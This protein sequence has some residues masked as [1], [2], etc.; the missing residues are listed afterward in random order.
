MKHA[1]AVLGLALLPLASPA[2]VQVQ[3]MFHGV[4][5]QLVDLDP[6]DGIAPAF[7]PGRASVGASLIALQP[8]G[9]ADFHSVHSKDMFRSITRS[10]SISPQTSEVQFVGDALDAFRMS[11]QVRSELDSALSGRTSETSASTYW[12]AEFWL[13]PGTQLKLVVKGTIDAQ[14][15]VLMD[16]HH[17]NQAFA[18]MSFGVRGPVDVR[19]Q[20]WYQSPGTTGTFSVHQERLFTLEYANHSMAS[21]PVTLTGTTAARQ[22]LAPV[23]EPAAILMFASGG[24]L[25]AAV[26]RRRAAQGRRAAGSSCS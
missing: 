21:V 5:L 18:L 13:T 26:A 24:V 20:L 2:Q 8:D 17:L 9:V 15:S 14:A 25:L 4:E 3:A 1:V 11:S 19:E 22:V 16:E 10:L 23:P 6:S 12:D 7:S